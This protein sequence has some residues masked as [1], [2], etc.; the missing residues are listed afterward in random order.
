LLGPAE[1]PRLPRSPR[2]PARHRGI[3]HHVDRPPRADGQAVP[4]HQGRLGREHAG[5][6]QGQPGGL[7]HQRIRVGEG[8]PGSVHLPLR[9]IS[10]EARSRAPHALSVRCSLRPMGEREFAMHRSSAG[11]LAAVLGTVVPGGCVLKP[12]H[13]ELRQEVAKLRKEVAESRETMAR[14]EELSSQLETKLGEA[15]EVLRRNQADLGLRVDNLEVEV[16]GLRGAAENADFM[17]SAAQQELKELRGDLDERLKSLEDKLN[18]ATNIPE[19]RTEL[20]AEAE[21]Q[22]KAKNYKGA[23][24]L[25]RT[26]ESRYPG[27]AKMSEV[28]FQIGLT[29]YSERDY[30]SAL[31]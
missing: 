1:P 10:C 24:K 4:L 11:I 18:E 21:R 22:V 28:K 20:W 17:A 31:G 26:F 14:A 30:K 3:Q 6:L 5:H 19:S 12:E 2:R 13:D 23:R 15:E 29:Y 25:W 8:S 16:Q 7:R 9:E 27:D